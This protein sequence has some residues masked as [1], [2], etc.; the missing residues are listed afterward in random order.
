MSKKTKGK[1]S[2]FEPKNFVV[3]GIAATAV[4]FIAVLM[5]LLV[6]TTT[7][8]EQSFDSA[9]WEAATN[10]AAKA[11]DTDEASDDATS[12]SGLTSVY[13]EE[14]VAVAAEAVPQAEDPAEETA[15]A[16]QNEGSSNAM[17]MP[18]T[19]AVTKDYSGDE[20]VYSQT[21]DDWRTHN[22]IDIAAEEGTDV[23]A[24][25]DGT[26]EAVTN[27]SMM[28]TT[29]II[30]HPS[31]LR[32]IYSNLAEKELVAPGDTVTKG[33]IIGKT[34]DTASEEVSEPPHLHFEI[35]LNEEPVNP[36]DYLPMESGE[37]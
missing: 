26:V 5:N 7:K 37:E 14:V 3:V 13:N 21:M 34:G 28:G 6:P 18:I 25:A 32:S 24:V 36:H 11:Y 29:V 1:G 33:S 27:S 12:D 17:A 35:S 9:A 2:V 22:G 19:G 31:G 10:E 16:P 15:P 4:I 8:N 23:Q 30:L 20:L